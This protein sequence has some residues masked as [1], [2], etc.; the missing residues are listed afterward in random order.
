MI[1]SISDRE[2]KLSQ[3]LFQMQEAAKD[4]AARNARLEE[5]ARIALETLEVSTEWD[6]SS[7][8]KQAMSMRAIMVLR[9][10]IAEQPEQKE[11]TDWSAA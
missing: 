3:C 11:A 8:G 5:A 2:R 1:T 7:T 6:M 10:A 4:L 9:K